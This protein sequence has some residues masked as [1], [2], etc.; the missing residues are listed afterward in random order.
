MEDETEAEW[1]VSSIYFSVS[2]RKYANWFFFYFIQWVTSFDQ[3]CFVYVL[4][5]FVYKFPTKKNSEKNGDIIMADP[6]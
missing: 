6:Y 3:I 2:D 4:L 5:N 1:I